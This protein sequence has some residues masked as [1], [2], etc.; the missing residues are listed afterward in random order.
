MGKVYWGLNNQIVLKKEKIVLTT[1]EIQ[2]AT[3]C[4]FKPL[5]TFREEQKM[6]MHVTLVIFIFLIT[7]SD[8]VLGNIRDGQCSK[9]K[10]ATIAGQDMPKLPT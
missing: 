9:N 4:H 1:F 5:Y 2:W 7:N 10:L 3:D 6:D 8:I